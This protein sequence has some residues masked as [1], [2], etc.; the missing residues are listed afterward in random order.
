MHNN[1]STTLEYLNERR[2]SALLV[3][4]PHSRACN[5]SKLFQVQR[6]M[7]SLEINLFGFLFQAL[8]IEGYQFQ[9]FTCIYITNTPLGQTL[10]SHFLFRFN[11]SKLVDLGEKLP[12]L[13]EKC[14]YFIFL[15]L[16]KFHRW[17]P[18]AFLG[19]SLVYFLFAP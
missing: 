7:C 2:S 19:V 6:E 12:S 9:S 17:D 18:L 5:S 3:Q 15:F 1:C 8:L 13:K 11:F 14:K 16:L 10:L 4:I